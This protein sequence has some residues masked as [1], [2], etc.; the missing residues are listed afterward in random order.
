LV[1]N[2][3]KMKQ[4]KIVTNSQPTIVEMEVIKLLNS[5]WLTAGGINA[6]YKH[7]HGAQGEHLQGH[8]VYSQALI[9][10]SE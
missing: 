10:D 7:E 1:E 6:T 5:G 2:T 8:L 4:Y 9:K 3:N